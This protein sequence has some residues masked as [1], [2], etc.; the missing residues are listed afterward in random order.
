[1]FVIVEVGVDLSYANGTSGLFARILLVKSLS[2]LFL[3]RS[4]HDYHLCGN[5]LVALQTYF[6]FSVVF[7]QIVCDPYLF[8]FLTVVNIS[9]IV[10]C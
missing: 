6:Q 2:D 8:E 10:L 4:I 7:N 3:L 9:D 1:M 5:T